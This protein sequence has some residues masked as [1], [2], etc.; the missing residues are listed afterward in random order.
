MAAKKR[1]I[2]IV[3][4]VED[5]TLERF[6]REALLELDYHRIEIR[7][8]RSP[9]GRGS[10]KQWVDGT[11]VNEV[12]ILRSKRHQKLAVLVGSDVD[13]MTLQN[14]RLRLQKSLQAA[15]MSDRGVDERIA[16]W[17]PQ[18]SIE[19]WLKHFQG[20]PVDED[21]NYKHQVRQP[22]MRRLAKAFVDQHQASDGLE[23]PA[24]T[25]AFDETRR[26]IE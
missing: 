14:R 6:C 9:G 25:S 18:W 21:T 24:L 16:Y 3:I 22:D 5:Q 20:E 26:I 17:L 13:E 11:F 10:G 15:K 23:L 12:R 7:V 1:G 4:V 8:E 19:T 2:R